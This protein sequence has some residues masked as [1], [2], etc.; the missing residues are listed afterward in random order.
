MPAPP[1]TNMHHLVDH[2][3]SFFSIPQGH[4]TRWP[5]VEVVEMDCSVQERRFEEQPISKYS[6]HPGSAHLALFFRD[7]ESGDI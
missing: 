4:N 7:F 1:P 6:I 3:D 5:L 2:T